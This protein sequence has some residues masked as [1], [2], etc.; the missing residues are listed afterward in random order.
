MAPKLPLPRGWKHRVRSSVLHILALSH[1][2]FTGLMAEAAPVGI[3]RF[4]Q[5]QV[6]GSGFTGHGTFQ[7]RDRTTR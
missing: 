2:T 5:A 1:Y 3:A 7:E 6:D 4:G